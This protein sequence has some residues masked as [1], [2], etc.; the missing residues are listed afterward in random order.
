MANLAWD[1]TERRWYDIGTI[2]LE[3]DIYTNSLRFQDAQPGDIIVGGG[4][5]AIIWDAHVQYDRRR[6]QWYI[7]NL[8]VIDA[9][10]AEIN[11]VTINGGDTGTPHWDTLR[12]L[13]DDGRLYENSL[14]ESNPNL[15]L[16]SVRDLSNRR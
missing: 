5:V 1:S 3:G 14:T 9:H 15:S 10:G 12:N 7:E 8:Q 13:L 2:H 6:R 16:R 11:R 4:H